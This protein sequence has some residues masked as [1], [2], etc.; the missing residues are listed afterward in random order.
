M[1]TE[2]GLN[3]FRRFHSVFVLALTLAVAGSLIYGCGPDGTYDPGLIQ[4]DAFVFHFG[5]FDLID[6]KIEA[7]IIDKD[8]N[9]ID[10][11]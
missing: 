5:R 3:V 1:K 10:S 9:I 6:K 7:S 2:C 4:K 8:G 11:F